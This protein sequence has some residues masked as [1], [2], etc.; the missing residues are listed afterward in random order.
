MSLFSRAVETRDISATD[1]FGPA[2]QSLGRGGAMRQAAVYA[3]IRYISD[4]WAQA[5]ATVTQTRNGSREIVETPLILS[6]PSPTLNLWDSRVQFVT[7]LKSRGN[8]FGL[9]DDFRRYCQ[10]IP[11]DFVSVDDSNPLAPKYYVNGRSV[12]LVQQGGNLVHARE[13]LRAGTVKGL[14]PIAAF[15]SSFEWADLA[16][17]YGRRWFKQ[18]SMPPAILQAKGSRVDGKVLAEARDDFVEAAAEGKPV[19][20]PGEWDYKKI[21]VTPEEAQFLQTIEAS[22]TEIA[23]IF[24][25]PPEEVGGKAG[26]SRTYSNREMDQTLFRIKNLGGVSGRAE[27]VGNS[28]LPFGQQVTYDLS[29]LE[30]PGLLE[31][32]RSITE[33]LK[34]GTLTLAEARHELGRRGIDQ[35]EIEQWQAWYATTKSESESDSTSRVEMPEGGTR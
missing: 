10:W 1:V 14:S 2:W 30:R 16:R 22:A 11:D 13:Q 34:N 28:L 19:A 25:V 31:Y 24:G 6:D 33:Q 32:M 9:V 35:T 20:L 5:T 29:R 17:Q 27:A 15:A 23:I 8:A 12:S 18:S 4:Q 7:E 21:T 26:S 3:A